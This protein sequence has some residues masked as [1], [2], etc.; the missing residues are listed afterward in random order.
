MLED[1][2]ILAELIQARWWLL[3]LPEQ[4]FLNMFYLICDI[5]TSTN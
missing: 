2:Q 3:H 4:K 5:I 1:T